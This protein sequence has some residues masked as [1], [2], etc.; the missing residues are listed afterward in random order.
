MNL[1]GELP[2]DSIIVRIISSSTRASV[3]P[4]KLGDQ[5]DPS[6]AA[7]IIVQKTCD[8]RCQSYDRREHPP[9]T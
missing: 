3:I 5:H 9:Y 1:I 8:D 6:E 7:P 2:I 4:F